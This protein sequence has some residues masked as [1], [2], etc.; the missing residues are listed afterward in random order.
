MMMLDDE[1]H[2]HITHAHMLLC[3]YL[4]TVKKYTY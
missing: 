4:L 2:Q 1:L 3:M